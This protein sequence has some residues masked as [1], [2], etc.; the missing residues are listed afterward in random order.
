MAY[1]NCIGVRVNVFIVF[2]ISEGVLPVFQ[3]VASCYL[4]TLHKNC[5]VRQKLFEYSD[6]AFEK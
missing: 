2:H 4:L 1:R 6:V 5:A 3:F